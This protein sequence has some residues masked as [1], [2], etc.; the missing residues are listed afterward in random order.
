MFDSLVSVRSGSAAT[1]A[2]VASLMSPLAVAAPTGEPPYAII[3]HWKLPGGGSW[4]YLTLDSPRHRLFIARG[5][6]VEVVDSDSGKFLGRIAG[7]QGVHGVAL[8][9]DLKRGFTSNGRANTVTEFDYDTLTVLRTAAVPGANPD[10]I[11]YDAS[12]KHLFTFNGRSQNATVYDASTLEVVAKLP[13]P[14]KPEFAIQD[15]H[16]HIFVN[17][18]SDRGQMVVID[19]NTLAVISTWALPDCARPSGL[20]FDAAHD[21]LFSVCDNKI[22]AI[23]N[24][25]TGAQIARAAIGEGP[26]AAAYDATRQLVLSSNDEGTL[27]VVRA[28]SA[29]K[30]VSAGTLATQRGARTM[31][32]DPASGRIYLVTADYEPPRPA[33]PE[34]PRPRPESKSDTF[35]ILVVAPNPL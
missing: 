29:D 35:T 4:D 1:I 2:L 34:Q 13:M 10:A 25:K 27:T 8:A 6:R 28:E 33:T 7:T 16:G 22:M 11:L 32:M 26:D 30:Y 19:I 3:A 9:P 17:I 15:S 21:R 24:A 23:T 20:A 5:D 18:E 31:A 12:H 14:G